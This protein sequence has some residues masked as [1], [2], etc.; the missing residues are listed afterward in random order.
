MQQ[1]TMTPAMICAVLLVNFCS[2]IYFTFILLPY[3]YFT[4][5]LCRQERKRYY[6][7]RQQAIDEPTEHLSLI[8]DGMDQNKTNVPHLIRIPK[9]CQ[10]LWCLE[11]ISLAALYVASAILGILTFS[12]GHTTVI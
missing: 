3:V 1:Y 7:D 2:R 8:V 6:A 5:D 10:N 4:L 9:S 11:R 12:N